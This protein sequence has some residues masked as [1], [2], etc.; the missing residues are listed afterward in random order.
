VTFSGLNRTAGVLALGREWYLSEAPGGF[1][2]TWRAGFDV[3]GLYGSEKLDLNELRHRTKV[4]YGTAIAAHT[5]LEYPCGACIWQVGF[6]VEVDFT[7][8][9]IL[10]DQNN[11]DVY[12]VNLLLNLGVRF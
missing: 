10:Q 5:D 6:R 1:G 3:D 12:D 2:A 8:S 4:F 9:E 7:F 11:A